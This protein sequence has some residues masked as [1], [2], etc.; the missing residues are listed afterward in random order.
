MLKGSGAHD[1]PHFHDAATGCN[2]WSADELILLSDKAPPQ[3]AKVS[4]MLLAFLLQV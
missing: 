1:P 4:Y 3:Y 2:L